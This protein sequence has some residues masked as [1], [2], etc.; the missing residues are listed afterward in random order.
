MFTRNEFVLVPVDL[1]WKHENVRAGCG[2]DGEGD[3]N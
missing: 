1:G 3:N 2:R